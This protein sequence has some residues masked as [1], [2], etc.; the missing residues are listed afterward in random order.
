MKHKWS[1]FHGPNHILSSLVHSPEKHGN[2]I[3]PGWPLIRWKPLCKIEDRN[4]SLWQFE[5]FETI[6]YSTSHRYE[7]KEIMN[8]LWICLNLS[9]Q[10][11]TKSHKNIEFHDNIKSQ[12][13]IKNNHIIKCHHNMKQQHNIKRYQSQIPP[14]YQSPPQNQERYLKVRKGYPKLAPSVHFRQPVWSEK[15]KKI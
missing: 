8:P 7:K 11:H 6:I 9:K 3:V 5:V 14:Q 10:K 1:H 4:C 2:P 13:N 15:V 12:C